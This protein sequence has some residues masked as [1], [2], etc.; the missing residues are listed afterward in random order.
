MSGRGSTVIKSMRDFDCVMRSQ[1]GELFGQDWCFAK[2]DAGGFIED[3]NM[4]RTISKT[5]CLERQ[6]FQNFLEVHVGMDLGFMMR[7][8]GLPL[9]RSPYFVDEEGDDLVVPH[10]M[11]TVGNVK[12]VAA[13]MNAVREQDLCGGVVAHH[14]E[15]EDAKALKEAINADH[16]CRLCH[17]PVDGRFAFKSEDCVHVFRRNPKSKKPTLRCQQCATLTKAPW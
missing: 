6:V 15:S 12:M 4:A 1:A 13:F 16:L 9:E 5:F 7:L 11:D 8:G 17:H 14:D 2:N 10:K 3:S